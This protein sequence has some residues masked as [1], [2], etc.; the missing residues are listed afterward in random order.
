MGKAAAIGNSRQSFRLVKET[1]EKRSTTASET[2][3]EKDGSAIHSQGRQLGRC[4]EHFEEQLNWPPATIALPVIQSDPEWNIEIGPT[5]LAEAEEAVGN[6]KRRRAARPDGLPADVYK[7][8]GRVLLV[9]LTE[10]L[11][12]IWESSMT[13][14]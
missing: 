2:I 11:T 9:T 12:S 7:N 1:G 3:A 8:G 10:V 6:L 5:T 4:A 13:P 14:L